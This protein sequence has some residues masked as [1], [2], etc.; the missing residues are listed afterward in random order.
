MLFTVLA[1][2]N[3]LGSNIRRLRLAAGLTCDELAEKAGLSSVKMIELG[4]VGSSAAPF[5][6]GW[7]LRV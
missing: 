1:V 7:R 6:P 5:P 3:I 4:R 2:V